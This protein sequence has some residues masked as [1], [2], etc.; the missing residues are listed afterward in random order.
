MPILAAGR[1]VI[2]VPARGNAE[3]LAI[4]LHGLRMDQADALRTATL[5][6]LDDQPGARQ[7]AAIDEVTRRYGAV[8]LRYDEVDGWPSV[9]A[10]FET[11]AEAVIAIVEAGAL[12][13]PGALVRAIGQVSRVAGAPDVVASTGAAPLDCF[14]SR[15]LPPRPALRGFGAVDEALTGC[16]EHA[17]WSVQRPSWMLVRRAIDR[18]PARPEDS[19]RNHLLTAI[20]TGRPVDD[21]RR[22][23]ARQLTPTTAEQALADVQAERRSPLARQDAVYWLPEPDGAGVGWSAARAEL[24]RDGAGRVVRRCTAPDQGTHGDASRRTGAWATMA[25]RAVQRGWRQ[26]VV[27][28]GCFAV[29]P[30]GLDRMRRDLDAGGHGA[31]LIGLRRRRTGSPGRGTE[32]PG[33]GTGPPGRGGLIA[34]VAPGPD[35]VHL[36]RTRPVD[37]AYSALAVLLSERALAELAVRLPDTPGPRPDAEDHQTD[38]G[39]V[40]DELTHAGRL[41]SVGQTEPAV[42]R[43]TPTGL[44]LRGAD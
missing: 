5:V 17:G 6:V 23:L 15:A 14:V 36:D 29:R 8:P 28:E 26:V 35:V 22:E 19:G 31:E 32:P 18:P 41:R 20:H 30:A 4:T 39:A 9:E 27:I 11:A 10:I 2:A 34:P 43:P 40:L 38:P 7:A 25:R 37:V 3:A 21:V 42:D 12:V 44:W 13:Q 24:A 33:R 16:W 1:P